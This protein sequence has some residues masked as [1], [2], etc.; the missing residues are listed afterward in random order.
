MGASM[1]YRQVNSERDLSTRGVIYG[2][3]GVGVKHVRP[4]EESHTVIETP[5]RLDK[6]DGTTLQKITIR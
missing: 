5:K 4:K 2:Y 1:I 6:F 3:Y